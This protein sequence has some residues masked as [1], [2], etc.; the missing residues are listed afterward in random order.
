MTDKIANLNILDLF[1]DKD[2][3]KVCA[4]M[5]RYSKLQFRNLVKIY[6]CDLSFTPMILADSFCQSEKARKNEFT[7]NLLDVPLITQFAANS[8]H[9]FV[10]AAY[11]SS[12]HCNGADLN[13]GCPQRWAKEQGLGCTMLKK[14]ELIYDIIRQCRNRISKPFS[15]SVKMRLL[16]DLEQTVDICKQL[17]MCGV[18]FLS[19]HARTANQLGGDINKVVLKL[20]KE[21]CN[22]PV[23]ANGGITSLEKCFELQ[24][25]TGCDGFMVANGLLTNPTLFSGSSVTSISCIQ[26]WTNIC[27]NSTIAYSNY[28][29]ELKK[30][31]W[32]ISEKPYNLTFQC[33][34][35]HLV[36]MLEKIL[37][38]KQKQVFNNLRTFSEVLGFL[39]TYFNIKPQLYEPEQF[40]KSVAVDVD[41]SG[42]DEVYQELKPTEDLCFVEKEIIYDCENTD[43]KYFNS[44]ISMEDSLDCDWSNIFFEND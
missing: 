26:N 39:E 33:F 6:N 35:H 2:L 16:N 28:E 1:K 15:V 21:N 14:P 19:V 34:H 23:I 32:T 42:R 13:C 25:E 24:D 38:R 44:K 12:P 17:E 37:P 40:F 7:T 3:V 18:S 43:G 5:V 10:G 4:P 8:V 41:Y 9:D 29:K 22:V 30:P 11:L 36:F 20:I 27:Y 31:K